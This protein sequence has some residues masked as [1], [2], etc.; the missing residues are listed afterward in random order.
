VESDF[1]ADFGALE[2]LPSVAWIPN[3]NPTCLLHWKLCSVVASMTLRDQLI[4]S[5]MPSERYQFC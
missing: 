5:P 4:L 2:R 3:S 1:A